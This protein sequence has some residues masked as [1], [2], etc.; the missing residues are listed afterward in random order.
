MENFRK[1][2]EKRS[3]DSLRKT[4]EKIIKHRNEFLPF[5]LYYITKERSKL[6]RIIIEIQSV[7]ICKDEKFDKLNKKDYPE[8]FKI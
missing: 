4:C 1:K 8:T 7:I 3:L 6:N 2:L 5:K